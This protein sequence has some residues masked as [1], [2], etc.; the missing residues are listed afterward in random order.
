MWVADL[1]AIADPPPVVTIIPIFW[2]LRF[3]DLQ[4]G[5]TSSQHILLVAALFPGITYEVP[6]MTPFEK[7]RSPFTKRM[8]EEMQIRGLA[9]STIDSYSYHV[10][11]FASFIGKR[12]ENASQEEIRNFQLWMKNELKCSWSQFNQAVSALRWFFTYVYKRDWSVRMI[13]FG[14]V[15]K[16][17]PNVLSYDEVCR[18]LEC[19]THPKHHAALATMYAAGLRVRET[20][21][22]MIHDIDSSRMMIKIVQGKGGKDRYVP[23]SPKLL[24]TLRAYYKIEKSKLYLFPGKT[25]DVPLHPAVLQDVCKMAAA[26]AKIN[27]RVTPHTLRHSYAT[28][29][30]EAGVD[31]MAISKLLGH[32]NF[33]TTM[34]YLHCRIQHLESTP[35]PY[36]W[37]PVRQCPK[38]IDPCIETHESNKAQ[39]KKQNPSEPK[40]PN[41]HQDG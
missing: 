38:W 3:F 27:K 40:P 29:L 17:L 4:S 18:L 11:R 13:P 22:L 16:K 5:W 32:R 10:D 1:E 28:G 21:H 15:P 20:T 25:R 19:V 30:L 9:N 8:I 23:L 33:T 41:S 37:L 24:E 36:D 7:R 14:H 2:G 35:S 34:I 39:Q 12:P 6:N 31:L 26:Q